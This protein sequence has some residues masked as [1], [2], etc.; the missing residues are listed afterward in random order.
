M[1]FL[2]GV[3][4]GA[5]MGHNRDARQAQ[6]T[7]FGAQQ[8][9]TQATAKAAAT[10]AATSTADAQRKNLADM[11][12]FIMSLPES[13]RMS[14]LQNTGGQFGL[15]PEYT[16][17]TLQ[18]IQ[19]NPTLLSDDSLTMFNST[20]GTRETLN[21]G[22]AITGSH[23]QTLATNYA[24]KVVS[25]GAALIGG[26]GAA[27]YENTKDIEPQ[28]APQSVREYQFAQQNGFGGSFADWQQLNRAK[29][30]TVNT[31]NQ[32]PQIG[33]IPSGYQAIQGEDGA[34]SMQMI[35][36][37]PASAEVAQATA[38]T[39]QEATKALR[40][41]ARFNPDGGD[42]AR[43]FDQAFGVQ[44][45]A[46]RNTP[47]HPARDAWASLQE[48]I[49]PQT[50]DALSAMKGSPSDRD[51]ALVQS[52]ASALNDP[53]ISPAEARIKLREVEEAYQ[54]ILSLPNV[55]SG[56]AAS[57]GAAITAGNLTQNADGSLRW[58]PN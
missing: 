20:Y 7:A 12:P 37:G 11:A 5:A 54:R 26:D 13:D 17:E 9:A 46:W 45:I 43:G 23:G 2:Q 53:L 34:Y 40:N 35:P 15:S 24:P 55:G 44:G 10:Q 36:G 19:A 49:G 41:I 58:S 52:A 30:V 51:M 39:E 21:D 27:L 29:G 25:D 38:D 48:V 14:Y 57:T 22:Q 8:R 56:G 50:L 6:Q 16:Q 42:L 3:N 18:A 47:S 32:G 33:A 1:S 4:Q 28:A 31:G